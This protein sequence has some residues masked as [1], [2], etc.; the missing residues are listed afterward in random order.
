[1]KHVI[2]YSFFF[3]VIFFIATSCKKP[4]DQIKYIPK[5]AGFVFDLNWKSLSE[6]ASKAN[7]NWDSILRSTR[8]PDSSIAKAKKRFDDFVHSGI[9]TEKNIFIFI[10]TGGSI[11]SG[12]STTV[13]VVA[14]L[15]NITSFEAYI[16][17]Q[18]GVSE[19]KKES[20]FSYVAFSNDN[21][22]VG[23][24]DDIAI[25]SGTEEKRKYPDS[26]GT[27][28]SKNSPQQALAPLFN[29]KEESVASIPEFKDLM[30]EKA[31]MLFWSNS[32]SMFNSVPMLGM[33]KIADLFKNSYGAGTVNFENGKV[34]A[35]FKSYCSKDLADILNKYKSSAADMNMVTRYPFPAS[36]YI[37]FNFNPQIITEIIRFGGLES[38]VNQYLQRQGLTLDDITK[39]FKGDFAIVFSDL[40]T[41]EKENGGRR[42]TA[43]L[44]FNATIG[45][46]G[47]YDKIVSKLADQGL[48]EMQ[49][50]QYVPKA[51]G[52]EFAYNMNGKNLIIATGNDLMQQYLSGKGN[53]A[54]PTDVANKSKGKTFALYFDINKIL[55]SFSTDTSSKSMQAA[56]A[57][58]NNV[59]AT[60]ENFNGKYVASDFELTTMNNSEN[61]L[62]ALIKFFV[63][64]SKQIE[65][66]SKKLQNEGMAGIDTSGMVEP[67][68]TED[69]K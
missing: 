66:E 54:I 13:G 36:G 19:I 64:A 58:F 20:N 47:A 18:E 53:A 51:M 61:S 52:D 35:H 55:E 17:K 57:T 7:I 67:P 38:T 44:L 62:A 5:D 24:N 42:P 46:K 63:S 25:L 4:T 60:R 11:M 10:K 39:A 26:S 21:L 65:Q 31:D 33:T 32:A 41:K 29:L 6:K 69:E 45:D 22:F 68:A 2:H 16:K 14:S 15:K 9:D 43:K 8:E 3:L 30:N 59:I 34:T 48:M 37:V 28:S 49:N 12:Q 23:W 56:K 1:M 50:G 27:S 40:G